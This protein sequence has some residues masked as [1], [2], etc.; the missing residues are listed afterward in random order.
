MLSSHHQCVRAFVIK[1]SLPFGKEDAKFQVQ[2]TQ[3]NYIKPSRFK[4]RLK[5]QDLLWEL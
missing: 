2:Q 3:N 4:K 1:Q 5:N